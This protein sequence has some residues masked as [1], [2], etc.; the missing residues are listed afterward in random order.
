M[1]EKA[2]LT[3]LGN[4]WVDEEDT[5]YWL[6]G[7]MGTEKLGCRSD[8]AELDVIMGQYI[9]DTAGIELGVY[10]KPLPDEERELLGRIAL[11]ELAAADGWFGMDGFPGVVE[12]EEP[13]AD[14]DVEAE[15]DCIKGVE[16]GFDD[17]IVVPNEMARVLDIAGAELDTA[18]GNVADGTTDA[19]LV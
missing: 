8:E 15:E 9:V 7:W 18:T 13:T 4:G 14:S 6:D 3:W 2:Q 12:D 5:I 10:V 16:V 1:T 11:E 17:R 19:E